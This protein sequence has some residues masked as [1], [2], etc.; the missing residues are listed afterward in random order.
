MSLRGCGW[1]SACWG[2]SRLGE[3]GHGLSQDF[4]EAVYNSDGCTE[5]FF[6]CV[7]AGGDVVWVLRRCTDKVCKCWNG[8]QCFLQGVA[9]CPQGRA[10][11]WRLGSGLRGFRPAQGGGHRG[12]RS[13]SG[14][15]YLPVRRGR[16]WG[17]GPCIAPASR[18]LA[19][20]SRV[21]WVV[22]L[23]LIMAGCKQGWLEDAAGVR[24]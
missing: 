20:C 9:G 13:R 12:S 6:T 15:P 14:P 5:S 16:S 18:G 3:Q 23:V 8:V 19:W 1:A 7:K 10:R 2:W 21:C 17:G 4:F 11:S 22:P 24:W